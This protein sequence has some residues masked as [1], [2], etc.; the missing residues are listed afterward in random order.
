[1]REPQRLQELGYVLDISRAHVLEL[2]T[3]KIT[4]AARSPQ[5]P[6]LAAGATVTI[7]FQFFTF[8]FVGKA[9]WIDGAIS[10][11]LVVWERGV[12][13]SAARFESFP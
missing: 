13:F 2:S 12:T 5:Q 10:S 3:L 7:T 1:V 9:I 4:Q 8:S 6:G 11:I